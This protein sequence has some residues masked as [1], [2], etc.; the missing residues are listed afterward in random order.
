MWY[1]YLDFDQLLN[2]VDNEY[3]LCVVWTETNHRLITCAHPSILEGLLVGLFVIQVSQDNGWR[4]NDQF[5]GLIV[6]CQLLPIW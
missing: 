2:A 3:V 4:A 6:A 1:T 5:P